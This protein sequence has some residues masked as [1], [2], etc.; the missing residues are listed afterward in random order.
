MEGVSRVSVENVNGQIDAQA[1]DRPYV[2]VRAVKR[3]SGGGAS[4]ILKQTEIRVR[5][6][7][8]EI[9]IETINPR[10]RR[11]FGFLDLEVATSGSTMSSSSRLQPRPDWKP[12]TGKLRPRG[13]R[14]TSPRT[15]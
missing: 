14:A 8:N 1:W 13:S 10:R 15:R 7:G 6:V 5:K 9:K 4:E 3:A 11:L 12:A 2:K